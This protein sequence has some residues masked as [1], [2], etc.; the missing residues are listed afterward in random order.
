METR[1]NSARESHEVKN[2]G[3]TDYISNTFQKLRTKVTINTGGINA[4]KKDNG[5][6]ED[7]RNF[8]A[9]NAIIV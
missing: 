3:N 8:V 9:E 4:I 2:C 1:E 5:I 7:G 6:C